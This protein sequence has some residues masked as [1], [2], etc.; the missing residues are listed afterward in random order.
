M[1]FQEEFSKE[2]TK[3]LLNHFTNVDKPVFCLINM[4]EVVKGALYARYSRS[5]KSLRRLFLDEF[6]SEGN[7]NTT[8][9]IDS[10]KAENLYERVFTQYG[11]DSVAQLGSAH[12]ACEQ[13]SNILTKILEWGRI[14]SYLEQSTRYIYYDQKIGDKFR[15]I[16]P[17]ELENSYIK[18]EYNETMDSIFETYS[19]VVRSLV[20]IYKE[21]FPR[22]E[23]VSAQAYNGT[24]RAKA[25]DVAR[26]FLPT[27]TISNVGMFA[28]GQA[29]EH[30]LLKMRIH[31][32]EEVRNYANMILVE[33]RKVIPSFLKRVDVENRGVEWSNY[34]KDNQENIE[35][36]VLKNLDNSPSK[37]PEVKLVEYEDDA[38]RKI[39]AYCLYSSSQKS[40]EELKKIVSKM[41]QE[42]IKN[43]LNSYTGNR[44]NRRHK[45][46]RA[47]E[48]SYYTFDILSDYGS[49][50][51]LQ[52]HRLMTIEWQKMNPEL[53]FN[54]PD[55][56]KKTKYEKECR[57]LVIK[58]KNLYEKL[59]KDCPQLKDYALLFGHNIRYSITLNVRQAFHL[60]ELR[61]AKQGHISYRKVCMKMHDQIRDIAKHENFYNLMNYTDHEE[62]ELQRLDSEV[63]QAKK[64]NLTNS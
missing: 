63:K 33:L 15:Y 61:T 51:D 31:K 13:S 12:L 32:S 42:E 40:V 48:N 28:S 46:G 2:E 3:I 37:S 25:C 35:N 44:K 47:F 62:Y 59:S 50:R 23:S 30:M 38:E 56:I 22:D 24:I 1:Y 16:T 18:D 26:Y 5:S 4:P 29:Y 19:K 41:P 57:D 39:A 53:G 11:D 64:E 7:L 8:I 54:F 6:W 58:S 45:P 36:Y 10:S 52:R 49:F 34:L 17:P 43:I 20:D 55:E 27:S 14:A 21:E 60:I 9:E